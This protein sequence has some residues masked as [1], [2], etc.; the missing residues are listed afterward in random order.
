MGETLDRV[1]RDQRGEKPLLVL[2]ATD[3]VPNGGSSSVAKVMQNS[4]TNSR[5]CVRYQLLACSDQEKDIGWMNELDEEFGEVDCTDDYLSEKREVLAVGL[6]K[7]FERSD[8]LMKA[9]LGPVSKKFDAWD[10]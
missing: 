8:W 9:L 4:I 2:I 5:I 7:Q 3:G 10:L 6:A 1:L